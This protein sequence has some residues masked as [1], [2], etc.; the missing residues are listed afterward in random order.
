MERRHSFDAIASAY[1][2]LGPHYPAE[3]YDAVFALIGAF[4][5]ANLPPPR[6][7]GRPLR[8]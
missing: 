5:R 7:R 6:L 2:R 3:M 8:L 1:D 4:A